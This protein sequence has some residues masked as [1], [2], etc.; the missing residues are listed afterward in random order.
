MSNK[1]PTRTAQV[2]VRVDTSNDGGYYLVG[3][4]TIDEAIVWMNEHAPGNR[5][6]IAPMISPDLWREEY[7]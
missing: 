7:E 6:L 5:K 2:A 4:M 3:P 1:E